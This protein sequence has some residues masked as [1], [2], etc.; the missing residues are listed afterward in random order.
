M[1][2]HA[3]QPAPIRAGP[4][5]GAWH[6]NAASLGVT[7]SLGYV[8]EGRRRE[9]RRNEPDEIIG[10]RMPREHWETIRRDDIA[11]DG[12]EPAREFLGL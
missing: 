7:R 1:V 11:L 5:T 8:E 9:L 10:Y 2:T 6:D 4:L 12:V 3:C